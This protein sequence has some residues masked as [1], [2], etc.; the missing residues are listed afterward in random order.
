MTFL[1]HCYAIAGP[2]IGKDCVFPFSDQG[3]IYNHCAKSFP[4]GMPKWCK[5]DRNEALSQS[6]S[7]YGIC[8]SG[9]DAVSGYIET[10][11]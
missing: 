11:P 3:K 1:D 8:H 9:Y 5:T 4:G 7:S 10:S 2:G 6:S